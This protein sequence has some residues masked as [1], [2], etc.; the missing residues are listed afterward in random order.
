MNPEC[1]NCKKLMSPL[2]MTLAVGDKEETKPLQMVISGIKVRDTKVY[3]YFECVWCHLVEL[4]RDMETET[5]IKKKLAVDR[6][7][8]VAELSHGKMT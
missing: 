8:S 1:R 6:D 4:Y 2:M 3:T 5:T 7:Q